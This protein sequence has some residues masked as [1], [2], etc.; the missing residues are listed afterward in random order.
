MALID[1]HDMDELKNRNEEH[2]WAAMEE[3]LAA[4]PAVCRCR[5]C[6]LDTAAITLNR[7]TPRYQ[8]Y[9]F[10][11]NNP[12][13]DA[14]H[15]KLVRETVAAASTQVGALLRRLPVRGSAYCL[16]FLPAMAA[17][18]ITA[19]VS[20]PPRKS[21]P[22]KASAVLTIF[23]ATGRITSSGRSI[24]RCARRAASGRVRT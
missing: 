4:N 18:S 16:S 1:Y 3:F 15:E 9:S 23:G 11:E 8:V 6:I 22:R 20:T 5:D 24:S 13:E 10:H 17:S 21:R 12:V 7:L 19:P 2:V 14:A